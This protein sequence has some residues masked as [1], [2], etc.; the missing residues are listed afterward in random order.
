M[1]TMSLQSIQALSPLDSRYAEQV[2]P[3]R[4]GLNTYQLMRQRFEIMLEWVIQL[5]HVT[6]LPNVT[7]WDEQLVHTLRQYLQ[8]NVDDWIVS[9]IALEATL[10][11]DVKAIE[12]VLH[13]ALKQHVDTTM[14]HFG[15]TSDDVNSVAY[16]RM[17]QGVQHTLS[18]QWQVTLQHLKTMAM[19]HASTMMMARTHGQMATPT[20][21]GKECL[22]FHNRLKLAIKRF[23]ALKVSAKWS[24][25]VGHW[26]AHDAAYHDVPWPDIAQR[27]VE[28][29]GVSYNNIT[30]QIEPHDVLSC[31][32]GM[33]AN[34]NSMYIDMCRDMWGYI[35][36]GVCQ[37][38]ALT[39]EVGS[40]TMPHK[41][42]PI[43]FENAEGNLLL[44]NGLLNTLSQWLPC[45]R[46]QR[47]LIDTTLLRN[48]GVA[49]GHGYLAYVNFQKGLS[50]LK[51]LGEPCEHWGILAEPIQIILKKHGIDVYDAVKHITRG[52]TVTQHTLHTWLK[53]LAL[54]DTLLQQL[55]QLTPEAYHGLAIQMASY[56]PYFH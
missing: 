27:F 3:I 38:I 6:P 10:Q 43:F 11:H 8:T 55:L 47:D 42:N 4:H 29:M 20:T 12:Q 32:L 34:V 44:S 53:S 52:Q 2:Q 17:W 1:N 25:A 37:Q 54:P 31:A 39:Q 40:S 14:V 50:R 35:S 24:G 7:Y 19:Q 23:L 33:L 15:C 49:V 22:V 51:V 56:E 36:L 45:S 41:V 26:S 18:E 28:R 30:T 13:A 9:A 48:L 46:Y 16:A 5:H 21:F